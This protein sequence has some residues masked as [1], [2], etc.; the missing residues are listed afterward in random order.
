MFELNLKGTPNTLTDEQLE[1]LAARTDGFSGSDIS[2][3]TQD[4]IFEPV[5]KCQMAEYFKKIPGVNG[6]P[7]NYIPCQPNEP[8]AM[9]MTMT[10]LPDAK[11]LLPPKVLY[12]DFREA[13]KRN[14][15]TVNQKDLEQQEEFTRDFGQEG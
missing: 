15:A 7:Y 11:A 2:T 13:L 12:E 14:K 6:M 3:L 4:A 1:D 9:K 8:G 5:R 10:E